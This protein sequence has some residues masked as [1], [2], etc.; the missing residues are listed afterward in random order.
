MALPERG[1]FFSEVYAF[2]LCPFLNGSF[3]TL[4][5]NVDE[6]QRWCQGLAISNTH[7]L[8][9]AMQPAEI[10]PKQPLITG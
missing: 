10:D 3:T 9:S 5:I 6:E 7:K 8:V 1:I 4:T 2:L